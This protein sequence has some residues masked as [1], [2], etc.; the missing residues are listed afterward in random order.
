M[1]VSTSFSQIQHVSRKS[2]NEKRVL[3]SHTRINCG[4]MWTKKGNGS[5]DGRDE[6]KALWDIHKTRLD[7]PHPIVRSDVFKEGS[8]RMEAMG[9]EFM[10]R[11]PRLNQ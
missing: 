3:Y 9:L 8:W 10:I 11:N 5:K 6:L 7:K 4:T 1:I 2:G